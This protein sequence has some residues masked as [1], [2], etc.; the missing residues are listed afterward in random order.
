MTPT[1]ISVRDPVGVGIILCAVGT[2]LIHLYLGFQ[3]FPLFVLNGLGY[4]G[5]LAA[6]ILPIPRIS[7]YRNPT[8]WVLVAYTALTIILW[9]LV[10]ARTP[11]G[12]SDKA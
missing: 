5:L 1:G 11:I 6:L 4:L 8:R 9:V 7:E 3:G 12:Y 2:A 10:G